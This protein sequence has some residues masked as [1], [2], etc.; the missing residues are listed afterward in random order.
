MELIQE[1]RQTNQL[2]TELNDNF[3]AFMNAMAEDAD[4]DALPLVDMDGNPV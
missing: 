3:L 1:Q 2:L 4:P